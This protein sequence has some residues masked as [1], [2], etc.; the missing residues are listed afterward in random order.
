MPHDNFVPNPAPTDPNVDPNATPN[1]NPNPV[2]PNDGDDRI[3]KDML[4]YKDENAQLRQIDDMKLRG[5]KEKEDW[6]TVAEHHETKAKEYE[7]KYHGLKDGLINEKKISALTIEAQRQG[8][9]PAS[10][11]P[12]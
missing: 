5:H 6:K 9:N 11:C 10:I 12:I 8:I 2:P 4:K 1:P 7:Q 3:K